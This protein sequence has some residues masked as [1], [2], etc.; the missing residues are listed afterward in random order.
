VE[1][2]SP[3]DFAVLKMG[4]II[5]PVDGNIIEDTTEIS[6]NLRKKSLNESL[7]MTMNRYGRSF[8]VPIQLQ[9]RP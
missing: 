2:H 6:Q 4:D 9:A 7:S 8:E 3:D 5:E 1:T